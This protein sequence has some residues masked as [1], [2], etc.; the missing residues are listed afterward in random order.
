M[1]SR[2][3]LPI[4]V[5]AAASAA[6]IL[7]CILLIAQIA[8]SPA[9]QESAA[10]AAKSASS[11]DAAFRTQAREFIEAELLL[12][13]ERATALGDHRYD[14]QLGDLSAD[15]FARAVVHAKKWLKTFRGDD[16]KAL[17]SADEADREFLIAQADGELLRIEQL[18]SYERE[19]EIYLPTSAV[20][21]LIK[22][23][24]APLASRMTSVTAREIAALKNLDAARHNLKPTLTP[25]VAIDIALQK[26]PGTLGLFGSDVPAAFAKVGDGPDKRAFVKANAYL[27]AAIEDYAR[28]LKSDLTPRAT[29]SYAIGA[30]AYRRM[31]NDADMVDLPLAKLEQ[32]GETELA[33]LRD[34][35]RK[36]AAAIDP[37]HSPAEVVQSLT[38]THPDTAEVIPTV[39]AGLA[40]IRAYV[41]AHHI[42]TIPSDIM[43]MVRETPPYARATTFASMDSPGPFEKSTEAFFYVTLPDP[44]WPE[45]KKEQLLALYSPTSISDISTHEVYP[46][47][48]VQ[49]LN[50]RLNPDV[51]RLVYHSGADVEGWGLYCEQMLVDKGLQGGKTEN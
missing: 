11:A 19:P 40:E 36:T 22:R 38:R 10:S 45:E 51:V 46:G 7:L 24:F 4:R 27:V 31:L 49:F 47:H 35:F 21:S 6:Q 34:D 37:K 32:V 41:I 48:Y 28:W 9:A 43:P 13:P 15:G 26:M 20:N 18:R 17:S 16:R 23:D 3:A 2:K 42:A 5:V 29:G 12:Y 39:A 25:K 1:R 33:R 30:D 50:N 44:S 8:T 14:N